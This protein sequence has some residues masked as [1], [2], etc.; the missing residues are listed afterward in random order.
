MYNKTIYNGV[1]H[2]LHAC[3]NDISVAEIHGSMVG[4]LCADQSVAYPIWLA[5]IGDDRRLVQKGENL[6][7]VL[8]ALFA[9]TR[10]DLVSDVFAFELM[11]P[12]DE[13][14][15]A[16]RAQALAQ[17][18]EGFLYG[19]GYVAV[20][21]DVEWPGDCTEI[22]RD[23]AEISKVDSNVEDET[24]EFALFELIEYVKVGVQLLQA[25]LQSMDDPGPVH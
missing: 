3:E 7:D 22:M 21:D 10:D 2:C 8:A 11:L 17:W 18:C 5:R 9:K 23:L 24:N 4:V 13:V 16:E 14:S 12:G 6:D 25:E 15:L 20:Q 1:Q 19:L